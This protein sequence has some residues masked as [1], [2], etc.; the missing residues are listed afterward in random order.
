MK[1]VVVIGAGPA[2]ST[3]AYELA[4]NGVDVLLIDRKQEIG[5]IKRCAEGLSKKH[6]EACELKPSKLW[7]RNEI[8]GAVIHAP[9][10]TSIEIKNHGYIIERKVFDKYLAIKAAKAGADV[11]A[12]VNVINAEKGTVITDK[13]GKIKTNLIVA[14][15][16]IE[17]KIA[18]MLGVNTTLKLNDLCSCAEYELMNVDVN[19][20]KIHI[21]LDNSIAPGGYAWIFPKNETFNVGIGVRASK[22][23]YAIDKLN[24]FVKKMEI[25]LNKVI[26]INIGG[27]PVGGILESFVSD[28]LLIIGDSAR[29]VNPIHGGGIA[30]AICSAKV[31]SFVAIE[32][33]EARD[34][35]KE[36]LKQYDE[37]WNEK[38]GKKIKNLLKLRDVLEKMSNE[39]LN[40]IANIIKTENIE[41]LMQGDLKILIKILVKHP[42]LL[43]Y[44]KLLW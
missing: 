4:K 28:G 12:G 11:R 22:Y 33:V 42:K 10:N 5:S 38:F 16:G 37:L 6:L 8:N 44:S 30:L 27:V 39:E 41:K 20:E 1:D 21:Y 43:K 31:A 13:L 36:R 15:D 26:E 25:S 23:F 40:E 34:F 35:S 32:A 3:I 19:K 17:S 18:R 24:E 9:N 7:I 2:G 14:C 29:Q